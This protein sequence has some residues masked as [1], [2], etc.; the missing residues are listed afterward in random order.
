L[1]DLLSWIKKF[2]AECFLLIFKWWH[3][4]L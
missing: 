3:I 2:N 4:L 1:R